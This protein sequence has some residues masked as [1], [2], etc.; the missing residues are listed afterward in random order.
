MSESGLDQESGLETA[1]FVQNLDFRRLILN[2]LHFY[3]FAWGSALGPE[4]GLETAYFSQNL[5]LIKNLQ[6]AY[7][8]HNLDSRQLILHFYILAILTPDSGLLSRPHLRI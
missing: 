2:S 4:S 7:F 3:I 6:T 8:V 5:D 1:Y